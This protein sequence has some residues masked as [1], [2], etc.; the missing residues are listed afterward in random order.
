MI[1]FTCAG[2]EKSST[3]FVHCDQLR[4]S[5]HRLCWEGAEA[6]WQVLAPLPIIYP[7]SHQVTFCWP[8]LLQVPA[9]PGSVVDEENWKLHYLAFS[10]HNWMHH[11]PTLQILY[12]KSTY[13][14]NI[15]DKPCDSNMK[16]NN[17][18]SITQMNILKGQVSIPPL[19]L[20]PNVTKYQFVRRFTCYSLLMRIRECR[21]ERFWHLQ[22]SAAGGH[23]SICPGERGIIRMSSGNSRGSCHHHNKPAHL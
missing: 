10:L 11:A 19:W 5:S 21:H 22:S 20:V 8:T 2:E 7:T 6:N 15:I 18:S 14:L 4:D 23:V 9:W 13:W 16:V 1:I 3:Q 12:F 17:N